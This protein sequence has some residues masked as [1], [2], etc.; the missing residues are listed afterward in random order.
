ML[1]LYILMYYKCLQLFSEG[2]YVYNKNELVFLRHP[3]TLN[4]R[5]LKQTQVGSYHV[6]VTCFWTTISLPNSC[7]LRITQGIFYYFKFPPFYHNNAMC[8]SHCSPFICPST[9]GSVHAFTMLKHDVNTFIWNLLGGF[10]SLKG[11][12][13]HGNLIESGIWFK[14]KQQL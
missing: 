8:S 6:L 10:L 1:Y 13:W 11:K 3:G 7:M 14:I 9:A 2:A 4:L 5:C 12:C